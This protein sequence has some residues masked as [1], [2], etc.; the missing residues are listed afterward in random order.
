MRIALASDHAGFQIKEF[1]KSRL[2]QL[3]HEVM[4]FGTDSEVPCDYPD[5]GKPASEAV[6]RGSCDRGVLVCGTGIGMSIAA[7]KVHGVFAA[8]CANGLQAELSRRHNNS[9]V[10]V[11]G[12]W[13][14]GKLLAEEILDRWLKAEFEGGRHARRVNKIES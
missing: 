3:G 14:V 1:L 11:I 2:Y 6:A 8:L 7:N 10:L 12:G 9:N 5:F 13:I 4:D